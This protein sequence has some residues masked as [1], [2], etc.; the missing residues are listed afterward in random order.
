MYCGCAFNDNVFYFVLVQIA[1][2]GLRVFVKLLQV[3]VE[4]GSFLV[5]VGI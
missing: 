1:K 3:L 5:I 4:I 2:S